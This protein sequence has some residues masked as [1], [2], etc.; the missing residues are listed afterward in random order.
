M[1]DPEK[2]AARVAKEQAGY[3]KEKKVKVEALVD[4]ENDDGTIVRLWGFDF[5]CST[6]M[7]DNKKP[8][9]TYTGSI[10]ESV[11]KTFKKIKRVK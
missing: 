10:P 1:F 5:V 4:N 2:D 3:E 11:A 8:V 6:E 9:C 7:D